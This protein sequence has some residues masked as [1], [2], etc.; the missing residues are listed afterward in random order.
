MPK[1]H[2][3][4]ESGQEDEKQR[5]RK[6][7]VV[8]QDT[9]EAQKAIIN[10]KKE[11][12]ELRKTSRDHENA[13]KK[14]EEDSVK[15]QQELDQAL[16]EIMNWVPKAIIDDHES[17]AKK[18]EEDS[19]KKQQELDQALEEIMNWVPKAIID[20]HRKQDTYYRLLRKAN[21]QIMKYQKQLNIP[22]S[23]FW[24]DEA[25]LI[26]E[27][28]QEEEVKDISLI[29]AQE[30]RKAK[31]GS[32][33]E[34]SKLNER[35]QTLEKQLDE[36]KAI[37]A[38]CPQKNFHWDSCVA[39]VAEKIP[40]LKEGCEMN[41]LCLTASPLEHPLLYPPDTR[42]IEWFKPAFRFLNVDLSGPYTTLLSRWIELERLNKWQNSGRL[43]NV[44]RPQELTTWIQYGHYDRKHIIIRPGD[45][46]RFSDTVWTWWL[47]L[48]P[49]WQ[50]TGTDGRPL[51]VMICKDDWEPLDQCGTNGWLSILACIRW[52]GES[53]KTVKDEAEKQKRTGDWLLLI[54]DVS[55]ML[56]GLIRYK[57]K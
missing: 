32:A 47:S 28:P 41:P 45:I 54:K 33:Q 27:Q 43:S 2:S 37:H 34:I 15:K 10:L 19:V 39:D 51:P 4:S 31:E 42:D 36:L 21:L 7:Q 20:A 57:Q 50:K 12:E 5:N 11:V 23:T 44:N 53:L 35:T 30:L 56:E 52:W 48:Q 3:L 16:E 29:L 8:F 17:A 46:K 1:C 13:A 9:P 22:E 25:D 49:T 55:E 38:S 6:V 24:I 18:A 26:T 14:A 40:S